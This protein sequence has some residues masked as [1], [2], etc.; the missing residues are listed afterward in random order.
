MKFTIPTFHTMKS[1]LLILLSV[2][3]FQSC[4]NVP[5]HEETIDI[6]KKVEAGLTTPVHIEDDRTWSIEERMAHYG[7][8]GVS[9]AVIHDGEI[10][11]TKTYGIMDKESRSPV[12]QGTL[13]QA[14]SISKPVTAYGALK[15][16]EL[17][18]M[19]L[20]ED[21][22]AYL[23]SWKLPDNEFTMES[24]VTLK[25]LLNHSAG[26]TVHGFLG[27]RPDL[28]VP[29]LVEV[30]N[31][32][33]PANSGAI[34]A[35]KRPGESFRYSGGGYTILQQMM[36][37][38]EGKPF[39]LLMKELV[40]E[41]L[42]MSNSTFD[43]PLHGIHLEKAATGY[44]PD[45]SMTGG[46]RHT[47]PEM[48]AA[49]LWTT[50]EDL[51]KFVVSIQKTLNEEGE[52]VL[53]RSM[54]SQ[55]LTPFV[56]DFIGLGVFITK[57]NDEVYFGHGGWDEGFSSEFMAHKDKGYGVV[58]MTNSNHPEF[59]SELIRSV[60]LTYDW[61]DFVPVYK[62]MKLDTASIARI[63]GRY[64]IDGNRLMDVY[65]KED[66]LFAQ[67]LGE[68]STELIRIS[69][70]TYVRREVNELIE[71]RSDSMD[72]ALNM[73]L[74]DPNDGTLISSYTR[75]DKNETLPMELLMAG[76]FDDALD[77]YR[78]LMQQD[79]QNPT[80]DEGQLNAIGYRIL[81]QGKLKLAQDIFK[82]NTL[83]YP[84]S[85]NVYDSYAEASMK[86]GDLELAIENYNRSLDLNP[87][88]TN[89]QLMIE[90]LEKSK[91][92]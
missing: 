79:P 4:S 10:K 85:S 35:D 1:L 86:I 8:P 57:L 84:N 23:T 42:T 88:N 3:L 2:I 15:L 40:L 92:N 82:V 45:G 66:V 50:A 76:D 27:Y 17:N 60:A 34:F 32:S 59:I 16:V 52:S 67:N 77:A 18:K 53:S 36:I 9:L 14:A 55:M 75:M 19:D 7:V 72:E 74:L 62:R 70:N 63:S 6:I 25:H 73:Q 58:V 5:P 91:E 49:G 43:Q 21:I 13:F 44:L 54:T 22:N 61:D 68:E 90:E 12:T 31:G 89:A 29:T 69:D 78:A 33:S 46:K 87:K 51:A 39:P 37:D 65:Q 81:N 24:K 38:V 41:P 80:I 64:R 20:N 26:I 11:W 28:P 56:E 83:L 71:F 48:A 30:L 47:Y